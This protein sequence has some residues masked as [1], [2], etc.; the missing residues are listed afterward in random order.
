MT[1]DGG[2]AQLTGGQMPWARTWLDPQREHLSPLCHG[3]PALGRGWA[4]GPEHQ[5]VGVL[6]PAQGYHNWHRNPPLPPAA[7]G[8]PGG[9]G[10]GRAVAPLSEGPRSPGS[11]ATPALTASPYALS[12]HRDR[13]QD[14]WLPAPT[15]L[16]TSP[17]CQSSP[18][19]PLSG[20]DSV[21][22]LES[23]FLGLSPLQAV[24][25]RLPPKDPAR[26]SAKSRGKLQRRECTQ[27]ARLA[28]APAKVT[29]R[30]ATDRQLGVHQALQGLPG[31]GHPSL[32]LAMQAP[33]G[34][35][36]EGWG[37]GL[38]PPRDPGCAMPPAPAEGLPLA[39]SRHRRGPAVRRLRRAWARS[40]VEWLA[41]A[42]PPLSQWEVGSRK[43]G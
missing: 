23:C 40:R 42:K 32:G 1:W 21:P 10:Q 39:L 18:P 17:C 20:C 7:P 5:D 27:R 33:G 2:S 29:D 37:W 24:S 22:C 4:P 34:A 13:T 25:C 9:L 16:T 6:V 31:P 14:S 12:R 30:P 28:G 8:A 36:G 11:Q 19:L 15:A 3:A 35:Q 26:G 41:P 38:G 43:P